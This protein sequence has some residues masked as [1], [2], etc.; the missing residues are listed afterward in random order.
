MNFLI[1][2]ADATGPRRSV[3]TVLHWEKKD[4]RQRQRQRTKSRIQKGNKRKRARNRC[5]RERVGWNKEKK[6]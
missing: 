6:K 5:N 3:T 4:E 2:E 1:S